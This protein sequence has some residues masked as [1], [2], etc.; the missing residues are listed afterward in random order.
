VQSPEEAH[1]ALDCADVRHIQIP[2]NLLDW[3]WQE[4]GIVDRLRAR[5]NV[6]V[7]LRSVFLQGLLV[8]HN[9]AIWPQI[10]GVNA[11][12]I[13]ATIDDLVA[14][15]G[16]ESPADLCLAYARGQDWADGIVIG[17]ETEVQLRTNL[18]LMEFSP[19]DP[20]SCRLIAD[21]LPRVPEAL[22][23]PALWPKAEH[24]HAA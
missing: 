4:L 14:E 8:S 13:I 2:F 22:L 5:A 7:H 16:R 1:I 15:F 6:T 17:M 24:K 12:Q 21:R 19:L 20:Q 3:R 10:P 9:P 11:Q 23:N 18:G